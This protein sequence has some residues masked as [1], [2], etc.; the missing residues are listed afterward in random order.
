MFDLKFELKN[1]GLNLTSFAN[2]VQLSPNT[3]SR[4]ARGE[5]QIPKW[6]KPFIINYKKS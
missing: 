5:V 3:V 1:L 2:E 4:W 6:V